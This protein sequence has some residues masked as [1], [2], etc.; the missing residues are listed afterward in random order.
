MDEAVL[1]VKQEEEFRSSN[2]ICF[3][4]MWLN[5]NHN[6]YTEGLTTIRADRD[7]VKSWKSV[8]GGAGGLGQSVLRCVQ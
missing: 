1:Q 4:E 3:M 5:E 2:L 7:K 6:V 8:G